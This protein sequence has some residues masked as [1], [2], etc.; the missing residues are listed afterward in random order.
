MSIK[1][2]I[3]VMTHYLPHMKYLLNIHSNVFHLR[4][5]CKWQR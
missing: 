5:G 4:C 2:A 3:Q 1:P